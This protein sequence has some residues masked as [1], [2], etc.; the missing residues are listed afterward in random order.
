GVSK[1][2]ITSIPVMRVEEGRTKSNAKAFAQRIGSEPI[3]SVDVISI[4]VHARR[5][6]NEFQKACGDEVEVGVIAIEDP[7]APA[8][9]WWRMKAGWMKLGKEIVGMAR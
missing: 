2:K 7:E 3:G 6:M 1:G 4:G 5:S 9:N 8:E